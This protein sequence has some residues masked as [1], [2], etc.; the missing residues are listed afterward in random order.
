MIA[1]ADEVFGRFPDRSFSGS[2]FVQVTGMPVIKSAAVVYLLDGLP[3]VARVLR[4]FG[5]Q[6]GGGYVLEV[7]QGIELVPSKP[8]E[9]HFTIN[10]DLMG[11]VTEFVSYF[12]SMNGV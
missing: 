5:V 3:D 7:A 11:S 1:N 10:E 9:A 2:I 12:G 6:G 8:T 4:F